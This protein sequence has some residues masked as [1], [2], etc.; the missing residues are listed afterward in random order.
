MTKQNYLLSALTVL[1][2]GIAF[3]ANAIDRQS[4]AKYAASLK[5]KKGASLKAALQ[6]LLKPKKTLAY[7]SGEGHTWS[8]FYKTDRNPKNNECY[9]R[10]S[11][12]KFFFTSSTSSGGKSQSESMLSA[13][14]DFLG[15]EDQE[16]L[17]MILSMMELLQTM[18]PEDFN[19]D[20]MDFAMNNMN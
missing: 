7:G 13:L 10:Y 6:P 9:N 15:E 17:E 2:L 12:E 18:N 14:K 19:M 1:F 8:G 5:G 11:S 16:Q 20:F 3:Q 4:L